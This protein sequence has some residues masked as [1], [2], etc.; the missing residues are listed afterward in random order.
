[1]E[2]SGVKLN[3]CVPFLATDSVCQTACTTPT[4]DKSLFFTQG[5]AQYISTNEDKIKAELVANGPI[6]AVFEVFSDFF[7]YESGVY[8]HLTG[9]FAGLHAVALVGYGTDALLNADYW[10][11]KNSW[12]SSFGESGYFRI[13]RGIF[14][15]YTVIY[16]YVFKG[17]NCIT[18][19]LRVIDKW[20]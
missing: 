20:L 8:K 6:S 2:D 16:V 4:A 12:G 9:D 3:S 11:V 5:W 7:H 19:I 13:A 1:M 18:Y 14:N 10:I 15:S 17:I